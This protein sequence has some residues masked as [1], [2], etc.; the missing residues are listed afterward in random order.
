MKYLREFYRALFFRNIFMCAIVNI[1]VNFGLM[2]NLEK[3]TYRPYTV[4]RIRYLLNW[5][6]LRCDVRT[7]RDKKGGAE[8]SFSEMFLRIL[9]SGMYARQTSV[10]ASLPSALLDTLAYRIIDSRGIQPY[11]IWYFF[12]FMYEV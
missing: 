4:R 6:M 1:L 12:Y 5:T 3:L 7:K 10:L 11:I 2:L 8:N 9:Q